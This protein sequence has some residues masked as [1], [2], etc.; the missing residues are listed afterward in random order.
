MPTK[1][2]LK[3]NIKKEITSLKKEILSL[4]NNVNEYKAVKKTDWREFKNK[5]KAAV[6]VLEHK[7]GEL[8]VI[9][10]N[11]DIIIPNKNNLTK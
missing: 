1:T 9:F 4:K 10:K 8:T 3:V 5:T 7:L 11:K 6:K 2:I